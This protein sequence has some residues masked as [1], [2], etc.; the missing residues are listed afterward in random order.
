MRCSNRTIAIYDDKSRCE[1]VSY[2]DD[3]ARRPH[4]FSPPRQTKQIKPKPSNEQI[5]PRVSLR[6]PELAPRE[7]GVQVQGGD[8]VGSVPDRGG[9]P[10][11]RRSAARSAAVLVPGVHM[12]QAPPLSYEHHFLRLG[13][14]GVNGMMLL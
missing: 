5:K 3:I 4:S 2:F 8:G 11:H 10:S 12:A 6:I 9:K 1:V 13:A 7:H 14:C